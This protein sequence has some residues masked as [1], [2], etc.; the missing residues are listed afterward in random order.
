MLIIESFLLPYWSEMLPFYPV[1][2][3]HKCMSFIWMFSV[4]WSV[5]S[6]PASV[7]Q[8]FFSFIFSLAHWFPFCQSNVLWRG[9]CSYFIL[10]DLSKWSVT[11]QQRFI[12]SLSDLLLVFKSWDHNL[13]FPFSSRSCWLIK[14]LK[15]LCLPLSIKPTESLTLISVAVASRLCSCLSTHP[16]CRCGRLNAEPSWG[17]RPSPGRPSG[18]PRRRRWAPGADTCNRVSC[19]ACH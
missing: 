8:R 15:P 9:T 19:V 17:Q 18:W 2:N 5:Y 12:V 1:L 4:H 13:F 3:F 10:K 14:E 6:S 7:P 16:T 11:L